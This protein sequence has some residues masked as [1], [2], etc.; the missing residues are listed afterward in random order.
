MDL[1]PNISKMNDGQIAVLRGP[2]RVAILQLAQSQ[3]APLDLVH[4]TTQ[5]EQYLTNGKKFEVANAEVKKLRDA[6]K[7]EYLGDFEKSKPAA[8]DKGQPATK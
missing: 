5:I 7:I 8:A 3:Q 4:A 2:G 1:L 6:A